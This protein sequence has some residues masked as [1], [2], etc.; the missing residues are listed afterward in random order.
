VA[1]A[2]MRPMA[3]CASAYM[4]IVRGGASGHADWLR[5]AGAQSVNMVSRVADWTGSDHFGKDGSG[6]ICFF[7]AMTGRKDFYHGFP[8]RGAAINI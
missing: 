5:G 7:L 4:D 1:A 6:C 3:P 8:A 2:R